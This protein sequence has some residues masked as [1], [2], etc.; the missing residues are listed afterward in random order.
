MRKSEDKKENAVELYREG[1]LSLE[2]A[3]KFADLYI[4]EFLERTIVAG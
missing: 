3:A 1:E 4:E 2:G